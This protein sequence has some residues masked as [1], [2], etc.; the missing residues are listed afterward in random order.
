MQCPLRGGGTKA[1]PE[2]PPG[3]LRWSRTI[4]QGRPCEYGEAGDGPP[5]VFLHGWGLGH[6]A[7]KRPLARL[8][9][10]GFRVLAPALPGFAGT[11]PL[12][13]SSDIHSF[14]QW[15]NDFMDAVGVTEPAVVIGHSFGGGV[16]IT[17]AHDFPARVKQ[18]VLVNSVGGA[19]WGGGERQLSDRLPWEWAMEFAKEFWP[20][21]KAYSVV[22][23][24][25]EDF[26]NNV[27]RSP[28]SM[29]SA[30]M[31]AAN[32]DLRD[33]LGQLRARQLPVVVLSGEDDGVIPMS[34]F[35]ALCGALG[36]EGQVLKGNHSWLLANPDAFDEVMANVVEL[37]TTLGGD[38]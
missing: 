20:P 12:P 21:H 29:W 36:I 33:E 6:H 24:A 7:Y 15:A 13:T 9:L 27:L 11:G 28:R 1:E 4:V 32:A 3:H 23:H 17:L 5:V 26:I 19:V 2:L 25:R 34:A 22:M 38:K 18:L 10:R 30:A 16:S 31:L 14:G 8:A 35:D 37:Q